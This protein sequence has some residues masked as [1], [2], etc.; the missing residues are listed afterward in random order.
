MRVFPSSRWL[1]SFCPAARRSA[2]AGEAPPVRINEDPYPSTYVRYPGVPTV[3]RHA[4]V[5]D[6]RRAADQRRH[7]RVFAD[8]ADPGG[9]R[10]RSFRRPR[11]RGD[12]RHRQIRHVR[13]SSTFTVTLATIPRPASMPTPTGTKPPIR[14]AP[15]VW[16]EHSVWPQDPG[17]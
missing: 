10:T 3:I 6:R 7:G 13:A 5:F 11:E 2:E 4:T 14:C 16:A 12:R 1:P 9:W 8:G 17:F 15:E